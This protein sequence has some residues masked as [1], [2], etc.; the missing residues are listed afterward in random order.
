MSTF[1]PTGQVSRNHIE[2]TLQYTKKHLTLY[3]KCKFI[4]SQDFL[5]NDDCQNLSGNKSFLLAYDPSALRA[6]LFFS[7]TI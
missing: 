2:M 5:Q 7:F 1:K 6:T 3:L 4:K